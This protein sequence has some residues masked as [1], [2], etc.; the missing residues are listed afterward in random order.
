MNSVTQLTEVYNRL[1]DYKN[2]ETNSGRL[3]WKKLKEDLSCFWNELFITPELLGFD[4]I[5]DFHFIPRLVHSNKPTHYFK[6]VLLLGFLS[7]NLKEVLFSHSSKQQ[8]SAPITNPQ[9]L[10]NDSFN[11]DVALSLLAKGQS[12]RSVSQT[13]GKSI[14]YLRQLALRHSIP[15]DRRQKFISEEIE[16]NIWR[17]AFIGLNRQ[18]IAKLNGCSIGAVESII[19]SHRGLSQWRSNLRHRVQ[20]RRYREEIIDFLSSEP[21]AS[22]GKVQKERRSAYT[23]LFK[24]DKK[25]LYTKLPPQMPKTYTPAIDWDARDRHISEIISKTVKSGAS[26]TAIDRQI[27]GHHWLTKYRDKLPLSIEAAKKII[28]LTNQP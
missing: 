9:A 25:W 11:S 21:S 28:E 26:L 20:L 12:L 13:C 18:D 27:G 22:R 1:L 7:E 2:Y 17:Q 6:H 10:R 16:R 24:H 4:S 3:R 14:G 19:Q 23:W 5:K 15:I 8:D